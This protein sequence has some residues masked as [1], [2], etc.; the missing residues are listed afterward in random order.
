MFYELRDRLPDVRF[1]GIQLSHRNRRGSLWMRPAAWWCQASDSARGAAVPIGGEVL[2]GA[3]EGSRT[4]RAKRFARSGNYAI[5]LDGD[6]VTVGGVDE[7]RDNIEHH[8]AFAFG[9][10]SNQ[11][12]ETIFAAWRYYPPIVSIIWRALLT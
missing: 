11:S 7:A 5:P 2:H 8:A 9:T 12:I 6:A 3:R 10:W 4:L 1:A